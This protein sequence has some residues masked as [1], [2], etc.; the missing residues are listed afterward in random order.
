M[1]FLSESFLK[2]HA[3]LFKNVECGLNFYD[4]TFKAG[5]PTSN[6]DF[7]MMEDIGVNR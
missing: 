3:I 2:I 5:R 4:G 6:T 1:N 7:P